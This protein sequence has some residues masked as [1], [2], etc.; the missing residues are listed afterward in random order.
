ML[1]FFPLF[2]DIVKHTWTSTTPHAN[3]PLTP[4]LNTTVPELAPPHTMESQVSTLDTHTD[5]DMETMD[6]VMTHTDMVMD[7]VVTATMED[8]EQFFRA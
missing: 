5:T 3:T 8:I 7:M 6:T 4:L 1:Q 2:P